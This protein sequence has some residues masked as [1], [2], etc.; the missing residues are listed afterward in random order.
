MRFA[1]SF[2]A[3]LVFTPAAASAAA[4]APQR[5]APLETVDLEL[6]IATDTSPSIDLAEAR[7]QRQGIVAAFRSAEVVRAI[8]SGSLGKIA[9][10]YVDWSS[11]PYTR[12]VLNWRVIRDK[13]S[14]D[15]FADALLRA[16]LNFGD[17]TAL[18]QMMELGAFLIETNN[19]QGTRRTIDIS[20]D[21][22]Q[23]HPGNVI[24]SREAVLAKGITINGLPIMADSYGPGDWGNYY[25]EID[26]Y[27]S[28]CIIGG[29]GAFIMPASGFQD[30]ANAVR[31]K[32]VLEISDATPRSSPRPQQPGMIRTAAQVQPP[33]LPPPPNAAGRLAEQRANCVTGG[34]DPISHR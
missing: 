15:A 24:E 21:G 26:K 30:F 16:P 1:A 14:A 5:A 6:V 23:N 22:P 32:L 33:R 18:T 2:F 3:A 8:Q 12:I 20:G 10:V 19:Y 17:D 9:V 27:Y 29:R 28:N 7:L 4:P 11:R 31:R 25:G 34:F 13:T